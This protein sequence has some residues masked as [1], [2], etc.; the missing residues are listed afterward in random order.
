MLLEMGFMARTDTP[1]D[2]D[3]RS[4]LGQNIGFTGTV[5]RSLTPDVEGRFNH[6][7]AP[8]VGTRIIKRPRESFKQVNEQGD[9]TSSIC[10]QDSTEGFNRWTRATRSTMRPG[11]PS[12]DAGESV[13]V[14][15][16]AV[17]LR[18]LLL[19]DLKFNRHTRR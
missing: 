13:G 8:P 17:L 4:V 5:S 7:P 19:A 3:H 1:K 12:K 14:S 9:S 10:S 15:T 16:N 18:G 6:E 11:S 2:F